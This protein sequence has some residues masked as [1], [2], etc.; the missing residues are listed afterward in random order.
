MRPTKEEVESALTRTAFFRE[1]ASSEDDK[2]MLVLAAEV[3]AL[4]EELAANDRLT[5]PYRRL[6]TKL[7]AALGDGWYEGGD[8]RFE[9]LVGPRYSTEAVDALASLLRELE[10]DGWPYNPPTAEALTS[11]LE[12]VRASRE[13]KL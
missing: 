10:E 8:S 3:V 11:R 6:I 12:A 4:R 1:A 2:A 5:E 9:K 7:T 13:P